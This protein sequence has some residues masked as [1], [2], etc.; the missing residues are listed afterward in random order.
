M[1]YDWCLPGQFF[2]LLAALPRVN[3]IGPVKHI[4]TLGNHWFRICH[5]TQQKCQ[6]FLLVVLVGEVALHCL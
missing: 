3:V 5:H 2:D 6:M 1:W 4:E